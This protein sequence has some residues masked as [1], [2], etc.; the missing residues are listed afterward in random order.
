MSWPNANRKAIGSQRN[1]RKRRSKQSP[2]RR[3]KRARRR[4]GTRRSDQAKPNRNTGSLPRA[5]FISV[6]LWL[7]RITRLNSENDGWA[8]RAL[9][10][11][12][13]GGGLDASPGPSA[14]P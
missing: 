1:Q 12:T 11:P 7:T 13:F 8:R 10:L 9:S 3:A 14:F 4:V 2:Q 6:G 5:V